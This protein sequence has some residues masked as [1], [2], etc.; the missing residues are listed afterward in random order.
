MNPN[1]LIYYKEADGGIQSLG[2]NFKNILLQKGLPISY[3]GDNKNVS[4]FYKNIDDFSVP[5]TLVLLN[6]RTEQLHKNPSVFDLYDN[7]DLCKSKDCYEYD[8]L[9][10]KLINLSGFRKSKTRKHRKKNNK[11]TRKK[12]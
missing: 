9:H 12:V 4:N 6:K 8:D 11:N 10:S 1:D 5:T 2:Y 3:A 7:I